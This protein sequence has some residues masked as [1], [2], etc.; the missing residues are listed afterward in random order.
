MRERE[1]PGTATNQPSITLTDPHNRIPAR[2][3]LQAYPGHAALA[4]GSH[5]PLWWMDTGGEGSQ[6]GMLEMPVHLFSF[7]LPFKTNG[8]LS[9]ECVCL[10]ACL[11]V[12][13]TGWIVVR[14]RKHAEMAWPLQAS[15]GSENE[16]LCR[17]SGGVPLTAMSPG[18]RV[19][20]GAHFKSVYICASHVLMSIYMYAFPSVYILLCRSLN[21]LL[22]TIYI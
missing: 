11:C 17:G 18:R 9:R 7:L 2:S 13:W 20:S 6:I 15:S 16:G 19:W 14:L 1:A 21:I 10:S 22:F 8:T 4:L 12:W 5:V 3:P